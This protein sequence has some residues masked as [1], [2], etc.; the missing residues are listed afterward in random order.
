RVLRAQGE[1]WVGMSAGK[2][3]DGRPQI[4]NVVP[5]SP[6]ERAGLD[7]GDIAVAVNGKEVTLENF[8]GAFRE[9]GGGGTGR[10]TVN[11][12]PDMRDF[13]LQ[14]G[15]DPHPSIRIERMEKPTALQKKI[16]ESWI[17]HPWPEKK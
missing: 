4:M 10:I 12:G 17:G 15:P 13:S 16:Y 9:R 3:D 7:R 2:S 14:L 6:A 11:R 8:A 1:G 5:G